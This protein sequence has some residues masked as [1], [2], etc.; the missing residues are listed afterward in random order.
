MVNW[1]ETFVRQKPPSA[2][3]WIV[4]T[5]SPVPGVG[6]RSEETFL[7]VEQALPAGFQQ[8][9]DT[10]NDLCLDD[11]IFLAKDMDPVVALELWPQLACP[12]QV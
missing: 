1:C 6:Y 2:K 5:A 3:L 4:T 7:W 11:Y 10:S 9:A 12:P 8:T